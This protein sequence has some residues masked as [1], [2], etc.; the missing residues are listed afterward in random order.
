M[1]RNG[2]LAIYGIAACHAFADLC[3]VAFVILVKQ[4]GAEIYCRLKGKPIL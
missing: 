1:Q 3:I 2:D 4:G